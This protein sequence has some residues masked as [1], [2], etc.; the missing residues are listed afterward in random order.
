MGQLS[1]GQHSMGQTG[2]SIRSTFFSVNVPMG[3]LSVGQTSNG[4]TEKGQLTGHRLRYKFID[5]G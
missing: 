3:L 1:M 4:S 5:V 2:V